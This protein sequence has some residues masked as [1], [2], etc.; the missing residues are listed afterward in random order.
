[1]YNVLKIACKVIETPSK[2]GSEY[3][4]PVSEQHSIL[5]L[6]EYLKNPQVR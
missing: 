3:F 4:Q 1:M 5:A 2:Y 6:P